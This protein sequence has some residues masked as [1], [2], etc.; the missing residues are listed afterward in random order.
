MKFQPL[1]MA[2]AISAVTRPVLEDDQRYQETAL[3][4]QGNLNKHISAWTVRMIA[5]DGVH[6]EFET[7]VSRLFLRNL[8]VGKWQALITPRGRPRLFEWPLILGNRVL[9]VFGGC[10]R[11]LIAAIGKGRLVKPKTAF[12]RVKHGTAPPILPPDFAACIS[13]K[14]DAKTCLLFAAD[15]W[16]RIDWARIDWVPNFAVLLKTWRRRQARR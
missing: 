3:F 7:V 13:R 2:S 5:P 14:N 12:G 6:S 8:A 4:W 11:R 15:Y 1:P 9:P 10:A 16:A